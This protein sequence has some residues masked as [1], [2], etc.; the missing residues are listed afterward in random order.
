VYDTQESNLDGILLAVTYV[1]SIL[2]YI[3]V[4]PKRIVCLCLKTLI[5]RYI[6]LHER[7]CSQR[8]TLCSTLKVL[9]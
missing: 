7:V 8:G 6:P 5:D 2:K 9:S 4:I 1:S 3:P